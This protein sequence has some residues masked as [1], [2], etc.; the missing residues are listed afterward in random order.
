MAF[1]AAVY[2]VP[3]VAAGRVVVVMLNGGGALTVMVIAWG[4]EDVLP[5]AEESVT[6]KVAE[7]LPIVVGV[8]LMTPVAMT[9][10]NPGG[11]APPVMFQL[12]GLVPPDS[13]SFWL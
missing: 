9:M 13:L 3:I 6:S 2:G 1:N 12:Y 11:S 10:L 4:A 7:L 8:P 5:P